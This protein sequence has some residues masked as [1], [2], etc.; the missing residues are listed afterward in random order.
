MVFREYPY[1]KKILKEFLKAGFLDDI[2]FNDTIEGFPQGSP[3]SPALANLAL[4]GLQ[5]AIGEEFL[6]TRYA[7]DFIT[8]SK[9]VEELK[10]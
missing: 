9:S 7:D 10:R 1:E 2:N 4:N 6:C 8:L 5:D 3:V